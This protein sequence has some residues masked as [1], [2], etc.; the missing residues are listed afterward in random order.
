MTDNYTK[1]YHPGTPFPAI[2][3]PTLTGESL[4][5]GVPAADVDWRI[6]VV[7]RGRHCPL[8]TKYLNAL[9]GYLEQL[10][11]MGIDVVAVSGDSEAQLREH[12]SR[13]EVSFPLGFG[14]TVEQMQQLG[15]YISEPRSE[16]ETD[17]PF[18]EPGLFVVNKQGQIQVVDIS[19]N[20]F[21]RPELSALVS[22]LGW[23]RNP[24]NHYPIRGMYR[25]V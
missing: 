7:Y 17:H 12:T 23:I 8:C 24:D 13:L 9:E 14:L 11:N 21:V 4:K 6:V 16:Q 19:N 3:V 10:R 1:K 5:L 20:P 2:E 25:D 18:A 15:L 22:G